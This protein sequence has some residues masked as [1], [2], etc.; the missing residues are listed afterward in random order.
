MRNFITTTDTRKA[1]TQPTMSV[2]SS[3]LVNEKPKAIIFKK[4]HADH[5]RHGKEERKLRRRNTR[6]TDHKAAYDCRTAARGARMIDR[7]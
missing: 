1:T 3:A 2:I 7:A 4:R 5:D 6:H